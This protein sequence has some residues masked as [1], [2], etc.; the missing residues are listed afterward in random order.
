M[1]K[2]YCLNCGCLAWPTLVDLDWKYAAARDEDLICMDCHNE[3][4]LEAY[5]YEFENGLLG[6]DNIACYLCHQITKDFLEKM[7]TYDQIDGVL[8]SQLPL[9]IY[10][11]VID[12][13][14][15]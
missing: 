6:R 10:W 9:P 3:H 5:A 13:I 14:L 4:V 1:S 8:S 15:V 7:D 2:V 12:H 11:E